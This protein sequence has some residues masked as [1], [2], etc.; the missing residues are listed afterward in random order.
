MVVVIVARP[1]IDRKNVPPAVMKMW[2]ERMYTRQ[3]RE[4]GPGPGSLDRDSYLSYNRQI[5]PL[6]MIYSFRAHIELSP[7]PPRSRLFK[8]P[9]KSKSARIVN[10]TS[11]LISSHYLSSHPCRSSNSFPPSFPPHFFFFSPRPV[12]LNAPLTIEIGQST[13]HLYAIDIT[14]LSSC[15]HP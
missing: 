6:K 9:T 15:S 8:R 5:Y 7:P 13:K 14:S 4:R 12:R 2:T 1:T 10:T 3:K 11:Q